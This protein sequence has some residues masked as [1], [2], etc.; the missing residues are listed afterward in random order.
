MHH[1]QHEARHATVPT[2]V[3]VAAVSQTLRFQESHSAALHPL[4]PCCSVFRRR[5]RFVTTLPS[6]YAS[7]F[8]SEGTAAGQG[9]WAT[10]W[11]T[12]TLT[13]LSTRLWV[14]MVTASR[15]KVSEI[16][17]SFILYLVSER[18][19]LWRSLAISFFFPG[20]CIFRA[21]L[22]LVVCSALSRCPLV[23]RMSCFG[24]VTCLSSV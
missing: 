2:Q 11:T 18:M 22:F 6:L 1:A 16:V 4:F 13:G 9:S 23:L 10:C 17:V 21:G 19:L 15:E 5:W 24:M 12:C 8:F 3:C 7:S 20:D 14:G